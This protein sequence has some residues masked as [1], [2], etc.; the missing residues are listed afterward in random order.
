[1]VSHLLSVHAKLVVAQAADVHPGFPDRF[2][3]A[4][5]LPQQISSANPGSLPQCGIQNTRFKGRLFRLRPCARQILHL[6][7]PAVSRGGFQGF[8]LITDI[9]TLAAFNLAGIPEASLPFPEAN[10]QPVALLAGSSLVC[11]ND[12]GES[13]RL[14]N[15]NGILA[16]LT[17][18]ISDSNCTH[19][20]SPFF[21]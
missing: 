21:L 12:P 17:A 2:L 4:E 10:P 20:T 14:V 15:A 16:V 18:K 6:Q 19:N 13:R 7:C 9:H 11:V 3:Q 5:L 8:S 1:M